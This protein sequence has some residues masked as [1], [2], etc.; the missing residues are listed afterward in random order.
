[1][2]PSSCLRSGLGDPGAG[3]GLHL[4][5]AAEPRQ[6]AFHRYA[7]PAERPR[8]A[9]AATEGE[10]REELSGGVSSET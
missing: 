7:P 2:I 1:M 10:A 9:D 5:H 4:N 3:F 6:E 8:L